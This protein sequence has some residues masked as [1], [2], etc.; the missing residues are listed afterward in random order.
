MFSTVHSIGIV[1]DEV[2]AFWEDLL[3]DSRLQ[4]PL[5]EGRSENVFLDDDW[6]TSDERDTK[7]RHISRVD[8]VRMSYRPTTPIAPPWPNVVHP[9]HLSDNV[10]ENTSDNVRENTSS[11]SSDTSVNKIASYIEGVLCENPFRS[12]ISIL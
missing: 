12:K 4:I 9:G 8:A 11:P 10:R 7:R 5:D 6:L 2:P 3:L 1:T